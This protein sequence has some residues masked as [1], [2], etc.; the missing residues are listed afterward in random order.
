MEVVYERKEVESKEIGSGGD[1]DFGSAMNQ[2]NSQY[3]STFFGPLFSI[4]AFSVD[5][6]VGSQV[7]I[8]CTSLA[9]RQ[10]TGDFGG[11]YGCLQLRM[12]RMQSM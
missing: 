11:V 12:K 4:T 2:F 7:S 9:I 8:T 5:N 3:H 1:G 10:F 6:W